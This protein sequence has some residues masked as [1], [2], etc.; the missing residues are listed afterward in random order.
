MAQVPSGLDSHRSAGNPSARV[1]AYSP[2]LAATTPSCFFPSRLAPIPPQRFGLVQLHRLPGA[3]LR[4]GPKMLF[5]K[6]PD[7]QQT[8][9]DRLISIFSVA[10]LARGYE[11][12]GRSRHW[13]KNIL[14]TFPPNHAGRCETQIR[15]SI[16][17][18]APTILSSSLGDGPAIQCRL[19]P[20][21]RPNPRA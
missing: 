13:L 2:S 11:A 16:H 7:R 17:R 9:Y 19:R 12:I 20:T 4:V 8:F 21:D 18:A 5:N 1:N 6:T 3:C 14:L 15:R 10:R